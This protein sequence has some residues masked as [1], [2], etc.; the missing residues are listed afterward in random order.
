[1]L[2]ARSSTGL[3]PRRGVILLVVL[4]FLSLFAMVGLSLVFYAEAA[5]SSFRI[6]REAESQALPDVDPELLLSYFLGQL[7]YDVPDDETGIYS[8]MRGHGLARSMYGLNYNKGPGGP[9][10]Y[11]DQDGVPLN[12]VPFNGTGRLHTKFPVAGV[13]APGTYNNPFK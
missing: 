6:S 5:A 11:E 9:I 7:V 13:A 1:M 10:Q 2:P 12:H 8:S 3:L 4:A